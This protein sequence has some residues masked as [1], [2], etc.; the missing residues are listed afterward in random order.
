M[1]SN[2]H[3]GIL[4]VMCS[5]VRIIDNFWQAHWSTVYNGRPLR[6]HCR[7]IF[8]RTRWSMDYG[9]SIVGWCVL[10]TLLSITEVL[11]VMH[12]VYLSAFAD[13]CLKWRIL[14]FSSNNIGKVFPDD[15]VCSMNPDPAHNRCVVPS[16]SVPNVVTLAAGGV[17]CRHYCLLFLFTSLWFNVM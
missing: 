16:H 4:K 17:F 5:N 11:R 10:I 13:L 1:S 3:F 8:Q 2:K 15:W 6:Y 12:V 14:P 7:L 9:M